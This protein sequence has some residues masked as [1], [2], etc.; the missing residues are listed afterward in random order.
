M[1]YTI[2]KC[3]AFYYTINKSLREE[4]EKI[5][6]LNTFLPKEL[7]IKIIK[8]SYIYFNCCYC[9]SLVCK[10]YTKKEYDKMNIDPLEPIILCS[11]C[12]RYHKEYI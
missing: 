1:L 7:C 12:I 4:E 6:I 10:E 2:N 8:M 5:E 3:A 11:T 9:K